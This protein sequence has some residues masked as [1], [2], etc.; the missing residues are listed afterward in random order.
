MTCLAGSMSR[1]EAILLVILAVDLRVPA[2]LGDDQIKPVL[3]NFFRREREVELDGKRKDVSLHSLEP[4]SQP[5]QVPTATEK[6]TKIYLCAEV[7]AVHVI[8]LSVRPVV[9]DTAGAL[10]AGLLDRVFGDVPV[11]AEEVE[12]VHLVVDLVGAG[13]RGLLDLGGGLVNRLFDRGGFIEGG[14]GFGSLVHLV[15]Q[16]DNLLPVGLGGDHG[17][18]CEGAGREE[19]K[20]EG[21]DEEHCCR[22]WLVRMK[23]KMEGGVDGR[24]KKER[25]GRDEG[26]YILIAMLMLKGLH[27][28]NSGGRAPRWYGQPIGSL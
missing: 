13:R 27:H 18:R 14:I 19:D 7:R 20:Q 22:V 5:K 28:R 15:R 8:P 10:F 6:P 1:N 9:Q 11:V 16:T 2:V 17:G 12:R 21:G 3:Q 4:R 25:R 23:W 24:R 26:A